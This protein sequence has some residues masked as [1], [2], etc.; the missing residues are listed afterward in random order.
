MGEIPGK[1]HRTVLKI[2][3]F[4]AYLISKGMPHWV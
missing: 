1:P 3:N 2:A 4:G